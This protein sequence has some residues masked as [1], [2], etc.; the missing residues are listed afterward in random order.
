M[1]TIQDAANAA[2][3]DALRGL[4]AMEKELGYTEA[5]QAAIGS[6]VANVGCCSPKLN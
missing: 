4:A 5:L 6:E 2:L 3:E 1:W